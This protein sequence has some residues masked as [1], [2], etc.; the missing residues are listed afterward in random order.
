MKVSRIVSDNSPA[1]KQIGNLL[2]QVSSRGGILPARQFRRLLADQHVEIWI[3]RDGA[4]I[5][6]MATLCV[7]SMLSKTIGF[8]EDVVVDE[9]YRGRG[10]G[11]LLMQKLIQRA[12]ARR[13]AHV[14]LTSRP[15][16]EAANAL[17]LKLGFE[18]RDTNVYRLKL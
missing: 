8:V 14:E 5:V 15:S 17:Y 12:R 10:L 16:R 7:F 4:K 13:C 6:G 3:V 18:Q 2:A 11:T 9:A 1:R